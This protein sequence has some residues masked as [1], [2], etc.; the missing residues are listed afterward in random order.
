MS[1]SFELIGVVPEFEDIECHARS[2]VAAA[3][4][5]GICAPIPLLALRA[6]NNANVGDRFF[7]SG[8]VNYLS[9]NMRCTAKAHGNPQS[10]IR[11]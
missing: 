7:N 4:K 1:A 11:N 6:S 5:Q 10:E 3:T 8:R 2:P 9:R